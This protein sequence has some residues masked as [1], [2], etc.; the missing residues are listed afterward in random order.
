MKRLCNDIGAMQLYCEHRF[1]GEN[2]KGYTTSLPKNQKHRTSDRTLDRFR[3]TEPSH[4][5]L[6]GT[7]RK[8]FTEGK[9]V[10]ISVIGQ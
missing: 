6:M 1:S 2:K 7:N 3:G 5:S 4:I 9:T 10:F 8:Q